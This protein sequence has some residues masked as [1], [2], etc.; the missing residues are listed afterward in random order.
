MKS[1]CRPPAGTQFLTRCGPWLTLRFYPR[2]QL[3]G[4]GSRPVFVFLDCLPSA[5]GVLPCG[6]EQQ[7]RP[8]VVHLRTNGVNR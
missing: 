3:A 8:S 2:S 4:A 7:V 1:A 6:R 5:E